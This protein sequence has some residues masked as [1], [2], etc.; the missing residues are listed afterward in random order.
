MLDQVGEETPNV[1]ILVNDEILLQQNP[2]TLLFNPILNI[3]IVTEPNAVKQTTVKGKQKEYLPLRHFI[4]TLDPNLIPLN[5]PTDKIIPILPSDLNILTLNI[6]GMSSYTTKLLE[7]HHSTD[8]SLTLAAEFR[9][10]KADIICFQ[11]TKIHPF[12]QNKSKLLESFLNVPGFDSILVPHQSTF[13]YSGV[14]TYIKSS[15]KL[16]YQIEVGFGSPSNISSPAISLTSNHNKS[17]LESESKYSELDSEGR[18]LVIHFENFSL[19]NCYFPNGYNK[20]ERNEFK[21]RFIKEFD[22]FCNKLHHSKRNFFIVGD[23]NITATPFDLHPKSFQPP[24]QTEQYLQRNFLAN[25]ISKF[26]L[27]DYFRFQY[28]TL[29]GYTW[30][31]H[32]NLKDRTVGSRVDYCLVQKKNLN[33]VNSIT[34]L[35][36]SFTSDHSGLLM[37]INFNMIQKPVVSQ[38]N[39]NINFNPETSSISFDSSLPP[40]DLHNI[41]PTSDFINFTK[42]PSIDTTKKSQNPDS[43]FTYVRIPIMVENFPISEVLL[44]TGANI[45]VISEDCLNT[46][47]AKGLEVQYVGIAGNVVGISNT[48]TPTL[49]KVKFKLSL[50]LTKNL[51]QKEVTFSI[52]KKVPRSIILG[53]PT[54]KQFGIK[55]DMNRELVTFE[56]SNGLEKEVKIFIDGFLP[57][58]TFLLDLP[59]P[60]VLKNPNL[61]YTESKILVEPHTSHTFSVAQKQFSTYLGPQLVVHNPSL[62]LFNNSVFLPNCLIDNS[63]EEFNQRIELQVTNTSDQHLV[64]PAGTPIGLSDPR[65]FQ[66]NFLCNISEEH[67]DNETLINYIHLMADLH[68]ATSPEELLR[69][70]KE[71]DLLQFQKSL[72][73]DSVNSFTAKEEF[74]YEDFNAEKKEILGRFNPLITNTFSPDQYA[75]MISLIEQYEGVFN[76][77]VITGT[78]T[79]PKMKINLKEHAMPSNSPPYRSGPAKDKEIRE[80]VLKMLSDGICVPS[81]SQFSSPVALVKKA[82]GTMRFVTDYRKLNEITIKDKYPLPRIDDAFLSL[83][84]NK[85][86]SI[87]DLLS[88]FWQLE[89]EE[90]DQYKTA[91]ITADGLYEYRKMPFGM[92]NAPS[93]FQRTM[94]TVLGGI[95]YVNCLVY[96]DDIVIFSKTID[97]HF[98]HL[99]LVLERLFDY[100]LKLKTKKANFF[101]TE[102]TFLGHRISQEGIE[103][104]PKKICELKTWPIPKTRLDLHKFLG[105][106]NYLSK[107]EPNFAQKSGPLYK[108]LY[109]FEL[110]ETGKETKFTF[111]EENLKVFD[112]L[113]IC[114]SKDIV[115]AI[116]TETDKLVIST[117]ASLEGLGYSC[118]IQVN[119]TTRKPVAF[120]SKRLQEVET[121]YSN[122]EREGL[123][124]YWAINCCQHLLY[125]KKFV[126]ETDHSAL[127]PILKKGDI[128]GKFARWMLQFVDYEFI[129]IHRSGKSNVLADVLSRTNF[130]EHTF[131]N[132]VAPSDIK[133]ILTPEFIPEETF[134]K[135]LFP[136][137]SPLSYLNSIN[138]MQSSD[139]VEHLLF[140]SNDF[141]SLDLSHF[142]TKEEFFAS[143]LKHPHKSKPNFLHSPSNS[144]FS[145][146]SNSSAFLFPLVSTLAVDGRE[147]F[148]VDQKNDPE[149][150]LFRTFLKEGTISDPDKKKFIVKHSEKLIIQ[151]DILY[152]VTQLP[153]SISSRK[154]TLLQLCVPLKLRDMI[155]EQFHEGLTSAHANSKMFVNLT[156]NF[157]WP[158]VAEDVDYHLKSCIRCNQS[159]PAPKFLNNLL[160]PIEPLLSVWYKVGI[161]AIGPFKKSLQGNT[162]LIVLTDYLTKYTEAIAVP[163]LKADVV[164]RALIEQVFL[165]QGFPLY[166][167]SDQGQP[168]ASLLMNRIC[169]LLGSKKTFSTSYYPQGNGLVERYNKTIISAIRAYVDRFNADDW[170]SLL[171]YILFG[172]N[173]SINTT[174]GEIPSY[175]QFGRDLRSPIALTTNVESFTPFPEPPPPFPSDFTTTVPPEATLDTSDDP[176]DLIEVLTDKTT[177]LKYIDPFKLNILKW[178]IFRI[179]SIFSSISKELI[180]HSNS[181]LTNQQLFQQFLEHFNVDLLFITKK[182]LKS[183]KTARRSISSLNLPEEIPNYSTFHKYFPGEF[184]SSSLSQYH[185]NIIIYYRPSSLGYNFKLCPPSNPF[186]LLIF[187]NSSFR[188]EPLTISPLQHSTFP[189]NPKILYESSRL[190]Q[191]KGLLSPLKLFILTDVPQ[192][193]VTLRDRS[194]I[195][196]SPQ[197]VAT[198]PPKKKRQINKLKPSSQIPLF[199]DSTLTLPLTPNQ[200]DELQSQTPEHI[201]SLPENPFFHQKL[202]DPNLQP[203]PPSKLISFVNQKFDL[204]NALMK[205]YISEKIK[206]DNEYLQTK[207]VPKIQKQQNSYK[208]QHDNKVKIIP[209]KVGDLV[210]YWLPKPHLHSLSKFAFSWDG[211]HRIIR[212]INDKT[213]SLL[214]TR[215]NSKIIFNTA[216][217][218][219]LRHFSPRKPLIDGSHVGVSDEELSTQSKNHLKGQVILNERINRRSD[220]RVPIT[221]LSLDGEVTEDGLHSQDQYVIERILNHRKL[222]NVEHEFLIKWEGYGD[223]WNSWELGSGLPSNLIQNYLKVYC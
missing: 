92:T 216:N 174:T 167:H 7:Q 142:S 154:Q 112:E 85:Y 219:Q 122:S 69:I 141:D 139:T 52:L 138:L 57:E 17:I 202:L 56:D 1:N 14:I 146:H 59:T 205:D 97:S 223:D 98:D 62:N 103:K 20:P 201:L 23:F 115:L 193:F 60:S 163:S 80:H 21:L 180:G 172:I 2:S 42:S 118:F 175:L 10:L 222:K 31:D 170:D 66:V 16:P 136:L 82:D 212:Q 162:H 181:N 218:G 123:A 178:D 49:G 149:F 128:T 29:K 189:P 190:F 87:I 194:K 93:C 125:N 96:I 120:G 22:Y 197:P 173:N 9:H 164:A 25:F 104:D 179:K 156:K 32:Y 206:F 6:N 145:R 75:R 89:I 107:F 113:R 76:S 155:L 54:Q 78:K 4:H 171:P 185:I 158:K 161:D 191:T 160:Q 157:W 132:K 5:S 151:N 68:N 153:E 67:S 30:Y 37:N 53:V 73:S 35:T 19:L 50:G 133:E 131:L 159:K 18:F 15:L 121:R 45:N 11:E 81:Q 135:T 111:S 101:Q 109:Q 105:F 169:R 214:Q 12:Q 39:K 130:D 137:F 186:E 34:H 211:P 195:S 24:E 144:D 134:N 129:I 26:K 95:K 99:E 40:N 114:M 106:V 90:A 83:G 71:D 203:V 177:P 176:P 217:I 84:G 58:V 119:E 94:D 150:K 143:F 108:K 86:F 208:N 183:E 44:D 140:N 168:F 47:R 13:G 165:K 210:W 124:I 70:I 102:I 3:N 127:I 200:T 207:L 27:I 46:L 220:L 192:V 88:G 184:I 64:I 209:F 55:I 182:T 221:N 147:D 33:Q 77:K 204:T 8:V 126:I 38:S 215:P 117:D 48:L 41:T 188:I 72:V 74:F 187:L 100:N 213:F 152:R 43:C 51:E 199:S 196:H 116:P 79:P 61:I 198:T 110:D 63:L 36:N 166:L 28:P 65:N 148:I 91:F